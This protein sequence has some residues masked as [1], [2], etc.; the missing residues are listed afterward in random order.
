MTYL[1]SLS[2]ILYCSHAEVK[3]RNEHIIPRNTTTG[4][5]CDLYAATDVPTYYCI[6]T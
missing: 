5:S 3:E 4:L 2:L 1:R 6:K